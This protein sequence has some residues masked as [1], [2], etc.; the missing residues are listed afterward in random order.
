MSSGH[1]HR[2]IRLHRDSRLLR[3][4]LVT[5]YTTS[6]RDKAHRSPFM[7]RMGMGMRY[8]MT[9]LGVLHRYLGVTVD[10]KE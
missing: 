6:D 10:V 1:R 9:L 2:T 7:Y 8:R 5:V 4:L 3:V